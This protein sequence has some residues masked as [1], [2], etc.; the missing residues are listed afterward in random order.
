MY[1]IGSRNSTGLDMAEQKADLVR[2]N[3]RLDELV[4]NVMGSNLG[5]AEFRAEYVKA[6]NLYRRVAVYDVGLASDLFLSA[7]MFS[8]HFKLDICNKVLKTSR[9]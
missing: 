9:A 5:T 6:T 2:F 1:C 4:D 7:L 3:R 8:Y